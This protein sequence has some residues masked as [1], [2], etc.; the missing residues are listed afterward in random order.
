MNIIYEDVLV[1]AFEG[2]PSKV[3]ITDLIEDL[4]AYVGTLPEDVSAEASVYLKCSGEESEAIL[5]FARPMTAAEEAESNRL[6]EEVRAE[7]EASHE[8]EARAHYEFLKKK[9]EGSS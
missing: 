1:K 8:R 7:R 2:S 3:L 5:C 4:R 9:F 6:Y